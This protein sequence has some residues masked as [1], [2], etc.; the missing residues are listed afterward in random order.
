VRF[1]RF[2]GKKRGHRRTGSQVWASLGDAAFH[3]ALLT[4]GLVF[5]GVLL[6]GVAVPEW[7]INQHFVPTECTVLGK[8]LARRTVVATDRSS[9]FTWQPCLRVRYEAAGRTVEAWSTP[10][11]STTTSDRARALAALAAWDL[12]DRV[13]GWYDPTN[14]ATVV[15]ERGYNW[16]M[17]LLTLLL[18]GALVSFG[19]MGLARAIRRWGRSEERCA[20]PS[21]FT[22]ILDPLAA[23]PRQAADHPGVPTCDDLVN[24]PGTVLAYRLPI[25]SP[26]NW[27][28]L[29]FGLFTLLWNSVLA[30][31]G[32]GA[33]IDL[34]GGRVDWLLL[35]LLVPFAVVGIGSLAVFVRRGLLTT[36]VGP[37]QLE[38]SAQPLR[39]G[40]SYQVLLAQ[41]GSG[42]MESLRLALR[43]EEQ[44]TFTQGTDTR[45]DRVLVWSRDIRSWSALQL[46]PGARF[47]AQ[48]VFT[49]PADAMHSFASE[50]N[51]VRWSI[52]VHGQ[53]VGWPEF[54]RT[55]PLVVFPPAPEIDRDGRPREVAP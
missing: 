22:E 19:G 55:F 3:A 43:L 44:A 4:V 14:P 25:D 52:A 39:P 29:G 5:A 31:L 51:S 7:R 40:G 9:S 30:V 41:G 45:T 2:F 38:I 21:R 1:P 27:K 49:I 46:A 26:E 10:S 13:P 32:V 17:W 54:I 35:A 34:L 20:V 23:G 36:A 37:T 42:T 48:E 8:G 28:L 18:P 6:S 47:E 50:H 12:D 24:S 33:G 11:R 53:P 16:W 15:L